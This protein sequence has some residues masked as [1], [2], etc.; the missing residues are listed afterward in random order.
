MAPCCRAPP[1]WTSSPPGST[2][3]RPSDLVAFNAPFEPART[4]YDWLSR[5]PAEVD[6]YVADPA[7]GFGLD[8][9]ATAGML[10]GSAPATADAE[11]LAAIRDD[12]PILL[13][14]VTPIRS[15][16]AARW[17]SSSPTAT[18][19]PVWPT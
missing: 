14:P 7:C 3:R 17:S 13:S 5:D 4:E 15:P 6:A 9:A 10:E 2:R 12:L 8:P 1:R 19:T 11:R 16:A 18:A